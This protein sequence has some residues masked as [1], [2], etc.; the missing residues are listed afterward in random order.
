MN[1]GVLDIRPVSIV[2][3]NE[4]YAFVSDGIEKGEAIVVSQLSKV[5]P[6]VELRTET[7][8]GSAATKP[9]PGVPVP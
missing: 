2:F 5:V 4:T 8:D 6:G 1:D 9:A 7:P 3:Q